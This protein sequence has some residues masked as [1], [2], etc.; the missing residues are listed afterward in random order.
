MAQ[1]LERLRASPVVQADETGWR[2]D[3]ANGYVWTFSTLS[4]RYFLRRGRDKGGVDEVLDQS[5]GGVLVSDFYAAYDHYP[6]LKQRCWA[7]LLRDIHNLKGLYPEDA[8]LAKWAAAVHELYAKAKAFA[9]P[10]AKQRRL[11][12]LELER[13]LLAR[14][15]PFLDDPSAVQGKLCRRI[16]RYIKSLPRTRYGELFLFVADPAVPSDNNA[17]ERSLRH[18][19]VSRKVSGGTRSQQ[20][21]PRENGGTDT[22]MTLASLFA[23][24]RAQGLDPL[25]AS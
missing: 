2:Q 10:G 25:A 18:L 21:L 6:G 7:H 14:C 8:K 4:E 20:S 22:K 12:Q 19:V 5:F 11:A 17:A 15:R 24:W 13:L 1:A 16:K 23:T 9:H 3:G